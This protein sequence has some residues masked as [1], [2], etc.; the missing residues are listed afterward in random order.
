MTLLQQQLF[1]IKDG[2]NVTSQIERR[3]VITTVAQVITAIA[4]EILRRYD[5]DM[6]S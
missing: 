4:V 3:I 2:F 1:R 6:I 5:F